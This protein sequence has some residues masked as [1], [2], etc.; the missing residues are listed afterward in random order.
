MGKNFFASLFTLF[1]FLFAYSVT[2]K[3]CKEC[4]DNKK[5]CDNET[6]LKKKVS[7]RKE[8]AQKCEE[9][10]NKCQSSCKD[11]KKDD[12]KKE[13]K[14]GTLKK[15]DTVKIK[16][17]LDGTRADGKAC[18]AIAGQCDPYIKVN[19]KRLE[20]KKNS[21]KDT[22]AEWSI[23]LDNV[24]ENGLFDLEIYDDDFGSDDLIAKGK[25]GLTPATGE[26]L[27]PSK[28]FITK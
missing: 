22:S 14:V 20:T 26:R 2:A 1:V 11:D 4:N 21:K 24:D 3:D 10:F 13:D 15:G 27:G 12:K 5:K 17:I 19:G 18:D 9:K 28:V 6:L 23:K 25:I 8:S 7:E 16:I